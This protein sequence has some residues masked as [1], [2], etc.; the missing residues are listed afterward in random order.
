MPSHDGVRL[1]EHQRR[2]PIPPDSGQGDPKQSVA[3]LE[4]SAIGR[5]FHRRQLLPQRQVLQD[6]FT[7]SAERQRQRSA[8]HDKQHYHAPIV[9][10]VGAEINADEFWRTSVVPPGSNARS[11]SV[12]ANDRRRWDSRHMVRVVMTVLLAIRSPA[13]MTPFLID[14][15]DSMSAT[16]RVG[17]ARDIPTSRPTWLRTRC[18]KARDFRA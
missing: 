9:A 15:V 17:G 11:A 8:D 18:T 14:L 1:H 7:M 4:V 10:G 2:A 16:S 5:P 3:R 6:Q 13:T 12:A